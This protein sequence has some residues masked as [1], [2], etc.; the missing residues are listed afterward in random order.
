MPP[1]T[2]ASFFFVNLTDLCQMSNAGN[3]SLNSLGYLSAKQNIDKAI[4]HGPFF[5]NLQCDDKSKTLCTQFP[6]QLTMHVTS[7]C[8]LDV[9]KKIRTS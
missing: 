7:D 1:L 6:L 3:I 5:C 2:L 4:L 9:Q 8:S